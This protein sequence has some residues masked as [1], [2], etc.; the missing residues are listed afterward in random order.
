MKPGR[1]RGRNAQVANAL[2]RKDFAAGE[3]AHG[4]Q[5][6]VHSAIPQ[7]PI[8]VVFDENDRAGSAVAFGAAFLGTGQAP[9]TQ[10]F[11]QCQVRRNTFRVNWLAIQYEFKRGARRI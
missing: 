7:F 1:R 8:G 11:Q 6:T 10:E 3:E 5:T 9:G 4:N 2:D